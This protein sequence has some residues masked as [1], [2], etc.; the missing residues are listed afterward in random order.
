MLGVDAFLQY[1][2]NNLIYKQLSKKSLK[3]K[4]KYLWVGGGKG[5]KEDGGQGLV[6][7]TRVTS[8]L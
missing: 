1:L 3:L 7:D 8:E 5:D 4:I 2:K 6:L